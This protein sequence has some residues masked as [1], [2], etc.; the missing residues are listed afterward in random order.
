M[1]EGQYAILQSYPEDKYVGGEMS[2]KGDT[3]CDLNIHPVGTQMDDLI[4][5]WISNDM[6]TILAEEEF[7]FPD[8]VIGKYFEIDSMGQSA[9]FIAEVNNRVV[10]L[11]CFGDFSMTAEIAATLMVNRNEQ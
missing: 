10:S 1:L 9:V 6:T 8:G 5:Q 4:N 3:K 2:E 7:A 11:T